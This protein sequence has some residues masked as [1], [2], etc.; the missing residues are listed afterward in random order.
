VWDPEHSHVTMA[1]TCPSRQRPIVSGRSTVE[2]AQ[3]PHSST[4][5]LDE[6]AVLCPRPQ[7]QIELD[8]VVPDVEEE[9]SAFSGGGG[10]G[11]EAIDSG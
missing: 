5:L 11:G 3:Q 1:G 4:R 7:D 10:R 9:V 6:G 2:L 8:H